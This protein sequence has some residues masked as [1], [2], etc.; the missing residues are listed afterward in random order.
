MQIGAKGIKNLL[1][2]IVMKKNYEKKNPKKHLS[3]HR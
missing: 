1:V 2:T 3:I